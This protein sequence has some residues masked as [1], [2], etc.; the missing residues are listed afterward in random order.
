VKTLLVTLKSTNFLTNFSPNFITTVR[1]SS[2]II[3]N[4]STATQGSTTE[5]NLTSS[6]ENITDSIFV[7]AS[8]SFNQSTSRDEPDEARASDD[9]E[10]TEEEQMIREMDR[11]LPTNE[12][13]VR[14]RNVAQSS[15]DSSQPSTSAAAVASESSQ[16]KEEDKISIK[17]KYLNDEIKTVNAY[18]NES[19]GNFKR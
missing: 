4:I 10:L 11:D 9:T 16:Q 2:S 17:L 1:R 5:E 3:S 6:V 19:V 12:C 18:L 13:S 8:E 15:T 7:E 14:R